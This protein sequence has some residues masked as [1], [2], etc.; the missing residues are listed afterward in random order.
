MPALFMNRRAAEGSSLGTLDVAGVCSKQWAIFPFSPP[1][2]QALPQTSTLKY[3]EGL[4]L[5]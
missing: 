5:R 2:F 1:A 4:G 3:T